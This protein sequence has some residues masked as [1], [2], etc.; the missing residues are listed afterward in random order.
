MLTK[1]EAVELARGSLE[2]KGPWFKFRLCMLYALIDKKIENAAES[3][4]AYLVYDMDDIPAMKY[5]PVMRM[6]YENLGFFVAY[7]T[8]NNRSKFVVSWDYDRFSESDKREI[9]FGYQ[10]RTFD[11]PDVHEHKEERKKNK[12]GN[13]GTMRWPRV[14]YYWQ[15]GGCW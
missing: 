2:H 11:D 12:N 7:R 3:G 6:Y 9:R 10:Y 15:N 14:L 5:F 8:G 4:K 1:D 13:D